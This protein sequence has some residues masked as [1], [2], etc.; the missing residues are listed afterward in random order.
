M[1][2][3]NSTLIWMMWQIDTSQKKD[4]P[5]LNLIRAIQFYTNKY[6]GVPNVAKLPESWSEDIKTPEGMTISFAK[7]IRDGQIMLSIDPSLQKTMLKKGKNK[8]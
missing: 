2:E 6:G 8:K 3:I 5:Q 4:L 1:T 7:S